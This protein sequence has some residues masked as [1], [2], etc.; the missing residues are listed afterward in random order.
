MFPGLHGVFLELHSIQ[1]CNSRNTKS[2]HT[3]NFGITWC[4]SGIAWLTTMSFRNYIT[5]KSPYFMF[6]G[7]HGVLP[8]LHGIQPYYSRYATMNK[9]IFLELYGVFLE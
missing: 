1:P 3:C 4:I 5:A 9:H 6:P 7:L 8:E 2:E